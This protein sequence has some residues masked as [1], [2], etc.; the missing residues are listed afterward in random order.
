MR[1]KLEKDVT[2][3]VNS[4][5]RR[6]DEFETYLRHT[7]ENFRKP[8]WLEPPQPE[9]GELARQT[10]LIGPKRKWLEGLKWFDRCLRMFEVVQKGAEENEAGIARGLQS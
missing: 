1:R 5:I 2:N 6:L 8:S 9:I 7:V 10:T 3:F 4:S